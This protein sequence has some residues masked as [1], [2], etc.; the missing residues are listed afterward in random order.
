MTSLVKLSIFPCL[1]PMGVGPPKVKFGAI[2]SRSY[3]KAP[4]KKNLASR[5]SK[6]SVNYKRSKLTFGIEESDFV[7]LEE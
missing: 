3:P 1:P 5:Y 7:I 2:L 6:F 4:Y